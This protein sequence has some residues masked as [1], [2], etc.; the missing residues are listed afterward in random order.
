MKRIISI[1][2]SI[3]FCILTALAGPV[4]S[5]SEWGIVVQPCAWCG[6]TNGIEVHHVRPQHVWPELAHDTNN[7]VCLCRRCHFTVGHRNNWTNCF[8]NLRAVLEIK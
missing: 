8:T 5:T 2:V 1:L 4:G 3:P 7:M 6:A